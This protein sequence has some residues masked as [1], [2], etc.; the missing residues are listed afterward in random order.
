MRNA[1]LVTSP[2][3]LPD[4]GTGRDRT[5]RDRTVLMSSP[6]AHTLNKTPAGRLRGE[7][8]GVSLV[9]ASCKAGQLCF[10]ARL[11]TNLL[12]GTDTPPPSPLQ[13]SL[14]TWLKP[15]PARHN[16]VFLRD[17]PIT[18]GEEEGAG[19]G[20]GGRQECVR[21]SERR[22]DRGSPGGFYLRRVFLFS[23]WGSSEA[24]QPFW[25]RPQP[26]RSGKVVQTES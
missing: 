3:R 25:R 12:P 4:R 23:F 13:P 1:T 22:G 16:G 19:L 6:Q 17:R 26:Q 5:G 15:E 21:T 14:I 8:G 20:Q 10:S 2:E 9:R 24:L 11:P 7:G 18:A